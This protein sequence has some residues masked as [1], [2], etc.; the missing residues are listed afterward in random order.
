V[1]SWCGGPASEANATLGPLLPIDATFITNYVALNTDNL[2]VYRTQIFTTDNAVTSSSVWH[3]QLYNLQTSTWDEYNS[4]VF[5][6]SAASYTGTMQ[7]PFGYSGYFAAHRSGQCP[8]GLPPQ[9]GDNVYLHSG[10]GTPALPPAGWSSLAP[11]MTGLTTTVVSPTASMGCFNNDTNNPATSG[12]ATNTFSVIHANNY[13]RILS[14]PDPGSACPNV[15]SSPGVIILGYYP[16]D[17][18][19]A[20][21]LPSVGGSGYVAI[22]DAFDDPNA[23]ADMNVYR[24]TFGLPTCTTG[25]GCFQKLNQAGLASGYPA[26]DPKWAGEISLDLDMVS[27]ICPHCHVILVEANSASGSDL[28]ASVLIAAAKIKAASAH[29]AIS[30]SYGGPEAPGAN[31]DALSNT[32]FYDQGASGITVV[33][34]AGDNAYAAGVQYPAASPQVVA[35]GGTTLYQDGSARGWSETVWGYPNATPVSG[36]GSGCSGFETQP[37]F[38]AA[39]VP[40]GCANRMINDVSAVADPNTGVAVYNTY[41]APGGWSVI[42]GTSA[43]APIVAGIYGLINASNS[44]YAQ[45]IY[46]NAGRPSGL[47]DV[48]SGTNG[49]C[50]T[51]YFCNAAVGY[52]GPTGNGTPNGICA[53]GAGFCPLGIARNPQSIAPAGAMR[54]VTSGPSEPICGPAKPGEYRCFAWRRTDIGVRPMGV[55]RY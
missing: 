6:A 11:T 46:T 3:I 15:T 45:S 10:A 37:A 33:A 2:P 52:D 42:G 34:S 1:L 41:P 35:V 4:T 14:I 40:A 36:T 27:A 44:T 8:G 25:T 47:H 30:N 26:A 12:A 49:T 51:A 38:Q 19:N 55:A 5:P 53:F 32:S 16:C 50:T 13:W 22:V 28:G 23:E 17:L 29:G 20:Y 18:I 24:T 21:N 43:S 39:V 48:T 9:A 31:G 7:A 54:R